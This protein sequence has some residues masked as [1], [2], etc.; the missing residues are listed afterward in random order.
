MEKSCDTDAARGRS[1]PACSRERAV[2]AGV[3]QSWFSIA[4]AY[5][6]FTGRFK[7]LGGRRPRRRLVVLKDR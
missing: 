1:G 3:K 2:A 5:R 4:D 7:A 6:F